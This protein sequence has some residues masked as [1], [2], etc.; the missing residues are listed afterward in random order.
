M[1][2]Q[3]QVSAIRINLKSTGRIG[4]FN[5]IRTHQ[6]FIEGGRVRNKRGA[7]IVML[8]FGI[9]TGGTY[10]YSAGR[11]FIAFIVPVV[12]TDL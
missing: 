2:T 1:F 7:H 10:I 3:P 9:Y 4:F 5:L 6:Q 12:P 11:F 8:F